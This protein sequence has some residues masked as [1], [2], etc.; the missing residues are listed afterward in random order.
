MFEHLRILEPSLAPNVLCDHNMVV[1]SL[2]GFLTIL[3]VS[4]V[5]V[6]VSYVPPPG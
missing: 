3:I 1:S 5:H 4:L 2:N 6:Q